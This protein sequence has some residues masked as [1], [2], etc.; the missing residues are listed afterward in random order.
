MA[1]QQVKPGGVL[2]ILT[3]EE[4]AQHLSDHTETLLRV[5]GKNAFLKRVVIQ[6]QSDGNGNVLIDVPIPD[7]FMWSVMAV[8]VTGNSAANPNL[9][10]FINDSNS[11]ANL[12]A[13]IAITSN[14]A[15]PQIVFF[16]KSQ[17]VFHSADLLIFHRSGTTPNAVWTVMLHVIEVPTSHEAQLLL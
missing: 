12:L 11:L 9:S 15:A 3:P 16:S 13:N 4:L 6:G 1:K 5:L 7:G 14:E 8:V 10:M 17:V 2:S